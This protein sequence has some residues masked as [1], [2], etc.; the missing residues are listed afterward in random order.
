M[1]AIMPPPDLSSRIHNERIN[2]AEEY[3]FV[4]A[5]KPPVHITLFDPFEIPVT[6]IPAFEK[7]MASIQKWADKQTPFEIKLNNFGFFDNPKNPVLYID[8]ALN[9]A[10]K[11]LH[12]GFINELKKYLPIEKKKS[13]Y[14]PHITIGYRDINPEVFPTIKLAYSKKRFKASFNCNA[15][16]LW[17]HNRQN[18]QVL[19]EYSFK[20]INNQLSLF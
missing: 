3:N 8:T 6:A 9:E 19:K 10:L 18:W 16:Y 1:F 12:R 11:E 20:N 4:R 15:F 14:K 5:L 7:E 17:K 2:F 13:G